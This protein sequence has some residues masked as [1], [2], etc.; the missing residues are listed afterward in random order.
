MDKI[1]FY[2]VD[3]IENIRKTELIICK[4]CDFPLV[5]PVFCQLCFS[6]YCKSC[7]HDC[8]VYCSNI[9]KSELTLNGKGTFDIL[10]SKLLVK[11]PVS[12]CEW[13]ELE[14]NI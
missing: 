14:R 6:F 11:C 8:T 4:K 3:K 5:Y 7:E 10:L 12:E 9:I 1:A 13:S 2:Y